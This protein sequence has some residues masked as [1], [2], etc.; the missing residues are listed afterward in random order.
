MVSRR[1]L[2]NVID[3]LGSI[4]SLT[5]KRDTLLNRET[6]TAAIMGVLLLDLPEDK[7]RHQEEENIFFSSFLHP[8]RWRSLSGEKLRMSEGASRSMLH[9]RD[10]TGL[11]FYLTVPKSRCQFYTLLGHP[12]GGRSSPVCT[13]HATLALL[14]AC[15]A[16]HLWPSRTAT[17]LI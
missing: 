12:R 5:I 2:V 4:R 3:L 8:F 14:F 1:G 11:H 6:D 16:T 15:R 13:T 17:L 10:P 9:Q 7:E